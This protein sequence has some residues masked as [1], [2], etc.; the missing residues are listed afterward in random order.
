MIMAT[1]VQVKDFGILRKDLCKSVARIIMSWTFKL[2]TCLKHC[3]HTLLDRIWSDLL[4]S[5]IITFRE[6]NRIVNTQFL[7]Y[8]EPCRIRG[9][10]TLIVMFVVSKRF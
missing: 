2:L 6:V 10:D 5:Y 7:E 9:D 8:R 3:N 1:W 4:L